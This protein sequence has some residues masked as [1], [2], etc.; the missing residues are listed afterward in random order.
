M[1]IARVLRGALKIRYLLLGGSIAGGSA[2]AKVQYIFCLSEQ[3]RYA[4]LFKAIHIVDTFYPD[5]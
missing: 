4:F 5:P 3:L 1:I 2:L